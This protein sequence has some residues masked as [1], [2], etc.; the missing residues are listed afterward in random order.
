MTPVVVDVEFAA[1]PL[2]LPL[3]VQVTE[4]DRELPS[5]LAPGEPAALNI[6]IPAKHATKMGHVSDAAVGCREGG[7]E[8]DPSQDHD[9]VLRL[10]GK[11][12]QINDSIR[13]EH[14]ERQ[15]N[16]VNG[17]RGPD[18]GHPRVTTPRYEEKEHHQNRRANAAHEEKP[19]ELPRAPYLFQLG[20]EHPKAEHIEKDVKETVVQEDIGAQLPYVS[21]VRHV[22]RSQSELRGEQRTDKHLNEIRDRARND[23]NL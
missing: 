3:T 15:Q 19:G 11:D 4:T 17:A 22:P 14:A 23:Q 7:K 6:D 13:E 10:N 20:A 12:H 21:L 5:T 2:P 1:Q 9:Q 16:S 18:R 8:S